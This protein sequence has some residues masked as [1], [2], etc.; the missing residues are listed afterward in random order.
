[1]Y[2]TALRNLVAHKGRLLMTA[3]AVMLGTAFVAG[4][5]IF[6]DTISQAT[7]NSY[8]KSFTDLSVMVTDK[9]AA[10]STEWKSAKGGAGLT[11]A[12]LARISALPGAA[13][14][15]PVISAFAAVADKKGNL[16]GPSWSAR[17]VNFVPNGSGIDARYPMVEGRGPSGEGE[18]ALDR[19]T[20]R[21]GGYKLGDKV[22]IATNGPAV[23]AVLTGVFTTDDPM[24]SS[25][26]SLILLPTSQAQRMLLTPGHY[27]D[28]EVTA[29]AGVS[30]AALKERVTPTVPSG[31]RFQVETASQLRDEQAALVAARTHNLEAVLLTFAGVSLFVGTFI[32][33]NTFT[34]LIAQRTKELALLRAIGADRSQ[35]TRSVLV[36]ALVI[37][38][39][40]SAAGLLAGVGIGLVM[41]TGL[42]SLSEGV[43]DGPLV[44]APT[45]VV[46]AL[47]VGVLVTVLSAVLP[48]LRAARVAPIAAL[49]SG[50]QPEAVKSLVVRNVIGSLTATGGVALIALSAMWAGPTA[51][52]AIEAGAVLAGVGVLILLPL[53]SRPMVAL[54][55]PLLTRLSGT[56]GR[57]ARL[58]AVRNPRRT[59]A[60]AGALGIGL[61]LI[62]TMTVI[63]TS[64]TDAVAET[65]NGGIRA[66]YAVVMANDHG[67]SPEIA[68][69]VTKAPGVTAASPV[70]RVDLNVDGATRTI[71]GL[72]ADSAE[73]L[74]HLS[75]TDGSAGALKQGQALIDSDLA[76]SGH[77]SAGSTMAVRRRDGTTGALTVGGVFHAN[78]MLSSVLLSTTALAGYEPNPYISETL[79]KGADGPTAALKQAIKKATGSNPVI[80]I[81]D[82]QG[83]QDQFSRTITSTLNLLYA[84]LAMSVLVAV[85]G[86]VNTMAMSVLERKREIGLLRAIG[87]DRGGIKRMVRLESAL[88]SA[89]GTVVGMVLG[90]YL[91]WAAVNTLVVELANITTV[92][93]YSRLSLFLVLTGVVGVLAAVWPA[94]QAARLDILDSIQTA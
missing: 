64:V 78:Q 7:K 14:V 53:L 11:D 55:G 29:K 18:I 20:A 42:K 19:E 34:M 84:L 61:T 86:V 49:S 65:V 85:L 90:S 44:V 56:P 51:R 66:D 69:A 92:I 81:L 43:P 6:S 60:T 88:I 52:T 35:V 28:I 62:T 68:K 54:A 30:Q 89:L 10:A 36:E 24:V 74:V 9:A 83:M 15:R 73:Q 79:V 38:L 23:D 58:N 71:E 2:R 37:G 48:A 45:T 41:K 47:A 1:M 27:T 93:P 4:T 91:A 59:G 3:L 72:D 17:A 87:L 80:E 46:T 22:R 57:L 94:R 40:A 16:I 76:A 32:I 31:S 8:S 50:D 82:R 77:L 12:T 21:R 63:G 70:A 33:A 39:S 26:S 67:L 25:G 75:M 5:M 13:K